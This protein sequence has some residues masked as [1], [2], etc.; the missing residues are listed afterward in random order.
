MS[1]SEGFSLWRTH[2][3]ATKGRINLDVSL[4]MFQL[5]VLFAF[6]VTPFPL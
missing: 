6:R 4:G 3:L 5:K 2:V 1:L